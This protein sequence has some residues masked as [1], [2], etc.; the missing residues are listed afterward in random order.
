MFL[1]QWLSYILFVCRRP[2]IPAVLE[3]EQINTRVNTSDNFI[4]T[5][6]YTISPQLGVK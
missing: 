3:I 4:L 2:A 5:P 1:K 6:Y